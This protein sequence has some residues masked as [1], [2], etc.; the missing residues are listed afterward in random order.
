MASETDTSKLHR[1]DRGY[2]RKIESTIQMMP[3][4]RRKGRTQII[5]LKA[6]RSSQGNRR[7]KAVQA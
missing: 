3:V 4:F 6:R 1:R 2:Y 5:M 7:S